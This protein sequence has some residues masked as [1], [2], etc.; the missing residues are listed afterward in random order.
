MTSF[1]FICLI[2][3]H[4]I[5]PWLHGAELAWEVALVSIIMA[6]GML[7]VSISK[8]DLFSNL[9]PIKT[10]LLIL[11]FWLFYLCVYFISIPIDVLSKIS[12]NSAYFYQL[13]ADTKMGYISVSSS[14][15]A[16]EWFELSSLVLLFIF[17]YL[18]LKRPTR[19]TTLVY[20]LIAVSLL[21]AVYSLLNLYTD[22]LYQLSKAIPPWGSDWKKATRGTFSYKNQ[23]AIYLAMCIPLVLGLMFDNLKKR[24]KELQ[25]SKLSRTLLY[26]LCS[27]IFILLCSGLLLFLVLTKTDS[28]GGNLVFMLVMSCVCIRYLFWQKQN[29][30]KRKALLSIFGVF[31]LLGLVFVNSVSFER[32]EKHGFNDSSRSKLHSVAL[33]VIADFPLFGSGPG[34]YPLIQ[35]NYKPITLGSSEMSKRA[36]SDY[37]ETLA[38]QGVFGMFLFSIAVLYMLKK[39]FWG[40]SRSQQGLLLG[41]QA[42]LLMLLLHSSFDYNVATF[43][44]SALFFTV[45]AI[46]LRLVEPPK[47]K[48]SAH[49]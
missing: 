21:T 2:T 23:Y 47:R 12:P 26:V 44:L 6:V 5:S 42:S 29:V 35:H 22:G 48:S 27:R 20:C 41:C 31:V 37:L 28:R 49:G 17:T 11:I 40:K 9:K 33:K 14:T 34:T 10:P 3:F 32:F 16:M 1:A 7:I 36:H 13:N 15:S 18:L 8:P 19:L 43:Y 30:N 46:A 4:T 39:I 25:L 24:K 38:T 45:L